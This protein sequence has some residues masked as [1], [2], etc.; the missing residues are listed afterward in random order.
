[1]IKPLATISAV[2]LYCAMLP[3]CAQPAADASGALTE[4]LAK[5][6]PGEKPDSIRPAPISGFHEV[7]YG[8]QIFYISDDAR[9]V[10]QGELLDL[11][12]RENVTETR[13]AELR[14]GLLQALDVNDTIVFA[15][16]GKT[17]HVIHV[18]TDV[19]CTY[20]RRLH[21]EIG[22]YN[23]RGIEVR[24][25][26]FPRSGADTPLYDKMVSVWCADDR[27][28]A[29][30]RAKNGQSVKTA[31]CANPVRAQL[32]LA[33]DF[34]VNGTPTLVFPDGSSMPG[35]VPADQLAAYLDAQTAAP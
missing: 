20:C 25:L 3:A 29:M 18:F 34:G 35:Y 5:I 22:E 16:K 2:L 7:S 10:L 23:E 33:A 32:A 24:Y 11:G 19:D 9:Y 1:M 28:A 17:K 12:A 8:A 14:V 15:P 21:A 31:Q 13:R 4:A 30:T 27:H 26:A 6:I